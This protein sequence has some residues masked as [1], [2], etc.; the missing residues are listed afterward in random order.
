MQSTPA[1]PPRIALGTSSS[2]TRRQIS[3]VRRHDA[4]TGPRYGTLGGDAGEVASAP[5]RAARTH[6]VERRLADDPRAVR[7]LRTPRVRRARGH[8]P[9]AARGPSCAGGDV[10]GYLENVEDEAVRA[11]W[12][13]DLLVLPGLELT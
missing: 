11:R 3:S 10:R 4:G 6:D 8:R 12:L 2:R 13:Y 7:S 1:R 5:L 9:C